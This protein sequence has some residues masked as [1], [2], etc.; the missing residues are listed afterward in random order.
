MTVPLNARG[1]TL[2]AIAFAATDDSG[3]RFDHADLT[4]ATELASRAALLVDNARL[5][6]EARSAVRA[7]DDMIAVISHDLRDPLQTISTAASAMRL[8]PQSLENGDSIESIALASMQM[9]RLVA[10]LLD[11]TLIEAGRLSIVREPVDLRDLLREAQ[12][13]L[14]P[15][16][17]AANVRIETRLGG[18]LPAVSIDRHR[19]MQ[20]L[21]NLMGNALK[22][23][24]AAGLV[25]LG[26][27][28]QDST[29]RIWVEDTGVGISPDQ[30][31]HV[32]DRFWQADRRARR[33]AGLGLAVA[34]GIVEAHG[35]QI[36]VTSRPG[37]GST[38]F[39][40][41]PLQSGAGDERMPRDPALAADARIV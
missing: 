5:Y 34:K 21:V 7:R 20:V 9:R 14:Q 29:I 30:L 8:A 39:F 18:D 22:F 24:A 15:Q 28:R 6:A 41:L 37:A 27:E 35:G 17:D 36:G 19:V 33:G 10:D 38:F 26:A 16:V 4:I 31:D 2:G 3:R 23:G 25:I 13:L 12:T 11:L 1:H 40:T 32:F